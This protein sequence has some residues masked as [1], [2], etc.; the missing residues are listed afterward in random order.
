MRY[1]SANERMGRFSIIDTQEHV[2]A[3]YGASLSPRTVA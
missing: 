2:S 3:R 1:E